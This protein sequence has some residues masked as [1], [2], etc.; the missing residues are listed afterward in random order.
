MDVEGAEV[1]PALDHLVL[2]CADLDEGIAL[3]EA[4]TGVRAAPGGSHPGRGTRNALLALEGRRYLEIMAPD[5]AQR[6][7]T[8]FT[9]LPGLARPRLVGWAAAASDLDAL[10]A[11]LR[12]AGVACDGPL[13]GART[14]P[15]G[16]ALRWRTLHLGDDRG[17][18]LPFLIDWAGTASHPAEAAPPGLRLR[19]LAASAPDGPALR[20]AYALLGLEV[21]IARGPPGLAA[22]LEGPHGALALGPREGGG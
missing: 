9:M 8:W 3:V 6:A 12:G 13:A 2:G 19:R 4:A 14:R 5:P 20:V 22:L 11:R 10:A 1:P 21:P 15:D 7:L 17:G 18:L 16:V